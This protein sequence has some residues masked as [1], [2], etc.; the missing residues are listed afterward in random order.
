MEVHISI[1]LRLGEMLYVNQRVICLNKLTNKFWKR[2]LHDHCLN[3]IKKGG[4]DIEKTQFN[5]VF[6]TFINRAIGLSTKQ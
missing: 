4:D 5:C 3:S 1:L 2:F 6:N